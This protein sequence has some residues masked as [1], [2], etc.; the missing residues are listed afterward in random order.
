M[1]A[2]E[3]LFLCFMFVTG[4]CLGSFLCC[5]VR[6]MDIKNSSKD[7]GTFETKRGKQKKVWDKNV[8]AGLGMRSVCLN[9]RYKLRWYDNIPIISWLI[10]KGRCR[11]CHA[12]IGLAEILSE[13]SLGIAWLALSLSMVLNTSPMS[14]VVFA[15]TIIFTI[16][17]WFL[18]IYDGL[19]GKLPVLELAASAMCAVVVLCLKIWERIVE[20]GYS[21]ELIWQPLLSVL[22]LSGPYLI[23]YLISKGKWVGDGDWFFAMVIALVLNS[24]WLSLITL[25]LMNVLACMYALLRHK[26]KGVIHLGPFLVA[27]FLVT[28]T[29]A[30]FWQSM[31]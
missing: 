28:V 17:I 12:R 23:L 18:A 6:R 31:V 8:D 7:E 10:L 4:S 27:A 13:L 21:D 15:G 1:E 3:T 19:F 11:K 5:Q 30:D 22:V 26:R 20:N 9:C 29:F 25:C 24:A 16:P 2:M 14:W